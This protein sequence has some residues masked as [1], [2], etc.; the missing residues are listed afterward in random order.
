MKNI[1]FLPKVLHEDIL[2]SI[3]KETDSVIGA[4]RKKFHQN[5]GAEKY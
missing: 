1:S 2:L 3:K 5:I 4:I